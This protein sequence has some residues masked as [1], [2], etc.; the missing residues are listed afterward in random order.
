MGTPPP[1]QP[2]QLLIAIFVPP[3]VRAIGTIVHCGIGSW[4][5]LVYRARSPERASLPLRPCSCGAF[6]FWYRA[7]TGGGW[8]RPF[9][10]INGN[11]SELIRPSVGKPIVWPVSSISMTESK[12]AFRFKETRTP[13]FYRGSYGM[14]CYFIRGRQVASACCPPASRTKMQS[15]GPI[16]CLQSARARLTLRGLGRC[17]FGHEVSVPP[18]A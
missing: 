10:S 5:R 11:T 2:L 8:A 16:S 17:S 3:C 9:S 1:C 18:V 14:R 15:R 6:F 13:S 12:R 4:A 7:R